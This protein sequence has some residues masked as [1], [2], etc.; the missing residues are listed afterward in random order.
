MN[1]AQVLAGIAALDGAEIIS[2]L[3]GGLISNS[4]LVARGLERFVLRMDTDIAV[5]LGLDRHA[6]TEV[7][8]SVSHHGLGPRLE[9]SDPERGL[10][11][12]RYIEGRVWGPADLHEPAKIDQLGGLLRQLHALNVVAQP[13]DLPGKIE[14][15]TKIIGTD[16][17]CAVAGRAQSLLRELTNYQ[18]HE[19]LCHNDL[20]FANIVEG[21]RLMLIDWEYAA[22]GNPLFDLAIIAEQ[23]QFDQDEEAGLLAAYFDDVSEEAS[24]SLACARLFYTHLSVLWLASVQQLRGLGEEQQAQLELAWLKLNQA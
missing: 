11:I 17:G 10:L 15:Y 5:T 12:T 21:Q 1:P 20:I 3:P 23:H 19:C 24:K 14:N 9:F 13:F 16:E 7:L 18:T 8:G 4:Y 6:E 22:V 2:E